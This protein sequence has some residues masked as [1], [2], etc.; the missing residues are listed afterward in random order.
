MK[1]RILSTLFIL[2]VSIVLIFLLVIEA[3]RWDFVVL[4]V[5]FEIIILNL[6]LNYKMWHKQARMFLK[7]M[8]GTR[9]IKKKNVHN[10]LHLQDENYEYQV[11]YNQLAE[12]DYNNKRQSS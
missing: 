12:K 5:I 4:F 9:K 11:E 2:L 6:W 8:F 3:I 1:F 7:R 10:Y